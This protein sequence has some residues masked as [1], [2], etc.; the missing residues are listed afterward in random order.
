MMFVPHRKH[1]YGSPRPVTE[2]VFLFTFPLGVPELQ[3]EEPRQ[4]SVLILGLW[5]FYIFTSR[6]LERLTVRDPPR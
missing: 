2:I 3:A 4:L 1:T 5:Q 6:V